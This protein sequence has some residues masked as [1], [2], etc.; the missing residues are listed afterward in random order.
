MNKNS[1]MDTIAALCTAP[2]GALN[3]LRISGTCALT[4]GKTVWQGRQELGKSNARKMLLG[5]VCSDPKDPASGEPCLAVFMPG[6]AS[7]T[8]EDTVELHCHGGSFAPKR[9]L[10]RVLSAG[11][12]SAGPGEF[13]RRAFLNGKMDLTQAEAVADLIAAKTESAAKLAERQLSGRI[14]SSIRI[15]R[16]KLTSLLA[17]ME[18]RLDF[19]EEALDW[20][21]PG[22]YLAL[23]DEVCA[24]VRKMLLS[25]Q[26]GAILRNGVNVVIA[27]RPNAGKS[28]LLNALLGFDRA[29]VTEIPGTTR[30]TLEEFVSLQNIPV[31]LTDTA[32]L[33]DAAPDPVEKLGIQRSLESLKGAAC[34]FWVLD[35][36]TP[37]TAEDS[38]RYL[39]Q[40]HPEHGS[41]IAVW[42][43]TDLS[44]SPA[45]LPELPE[46]PSVRISALKGHGLDDLLNC[47]AETVWHMPPDQE[48]SDCEV[49]A[50]HA[51]LLQNALTMLER[52]IGEVRQESWELAAF[53]LREALYS[54]G[55]I[56]GETAAPDILEEIF[57]RFCIGK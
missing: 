46:I 33:R 41:M 22:K 13:T 6:P 18:S 50:R 27:G 14:G 12:R 16:E 24:S 52:C 5:K 26:N 29:I 3:I 42:N 54:L 30:D 47:F 31:R 48:A 4:V 9:L 2:G 38:V 7:Y 19:S 17:E 56:T 51:E 43:K 15:W 25:A 39:K 36:S 8:G 55:T 35:A 32:G 11:A 53:S 45:R 20:D 10:Q 1:D 49:S 21:S 28:S 34:I 37:Q 57:S 40:H 23:L 44:S